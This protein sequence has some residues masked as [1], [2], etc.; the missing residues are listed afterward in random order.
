[1]SLWGN[2]VT[3]GGG[4]ADCYWQVQ[5]YSHSGLVLMHVEYV[6]DGEN[7]EYG[8]S[9]SWAISPGG[10]AVPGILQ[11]IHQNLTVYSYSLPSD[12]LLHFDSSATTDVGLAGVTWAVQGSAAI[13]T[14]VKKF[15]NSS[16]YFSS[17]GYL[18][19]TAAND[20]FNFGSGD[21]TIDFWLYVASPSTRMALFAMNADC[22][23]SMDLWRSKPNMWFSSNGNWNVAQAD[24]TG[25]ANS[26]AGSI[27]VAANTWTHIA[28]VRSGNHLLSFVNG[29]VNKD[30]TISGG[31]SLY[32]DSKRFRIGRW[33]EGSYPL[34]GYI[35]EFRVLKGI[36][37]WTEAFTPPVEPYA[38]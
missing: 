15:G 31:V 3:L 7:A 20:V 14:A 6:K 5:Y 29:R 24:D 37:A 2:P 17:G 34:T 8:S 25:A 9:V 1:M 36:A 22:R 19:T 26:G 13:S 16:L 32:Y 18:Q 28:Y 10:E 23:I 21:F 12:V 4:A 35:D 33:G 11:N 38:E 27:A 30:L